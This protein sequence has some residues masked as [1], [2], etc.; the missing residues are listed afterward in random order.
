MLGRVI[1][2]GVALSLISLSGV[3]ADEP[4]PEEE[5]VVPPPAPPPAPEPVSAP[6]PPY[7]ELKQRTIAAGLG[8]SWGGGTIKFD[9]EDHAFSVKGLS[10]GELGASSLFARSRA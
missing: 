6:P 5:I 7:L 3:Y 1:A 8:L 4:A 10:V 2:M 9:G